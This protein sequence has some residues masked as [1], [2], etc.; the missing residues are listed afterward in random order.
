MDRE[1]LLRNLE[2]VGRIKEKKKIWAYMY[3]SPW[4]SCGKGRYQR[5]KLIEIETE[6]LEFGQLSFTFVWGWP[7]PDWNDYRYD[8]YGVTWA[9]RK[10]DIKP[11]ESPADCKEIIEAG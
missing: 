3:G 1:E 11:A 4:T 9:F 8:D 7:G 5:D 10:E 2:L 6:K